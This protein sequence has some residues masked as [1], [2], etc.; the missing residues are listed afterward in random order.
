MLYVL[1]G[2]DD[3][4]IARS[5]EAIKKQIGDQAALETATTTL[6]GQKLTLDELRTVCETVPFLTEKRLVIVDGLLERFET[7]NRP[8]RQSRTHSAKSQPEGHKPF[9]DYMGNI[10]DSTVLVLTD[11]LISKAN[12]LLKDLPGK[13]TVQ[14]FPLLRE[15]QLREWV[16]K[17]V[18]AEGGNISPRAANLLARLV[19]SNLWI[20]SSEIN[21]LNL[22]AP[23]RPIEEDDIETMVGYSQQ[24]TVFIMI[25]AVLEFKAEL[26]EQSLHRLLQTGAASGYLLTMLA[27]QVQ[28]IVWASELK[29]QKRTNM[30]IQGKLGLNSEYVLRKVLEQAAR[31][32]LPRLKEVYHKL[33]ETDISIKTGKFD[34]DFALVILVAELSRRTKAPSTQS[35]GSLK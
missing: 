2:Q 23:G 3:Y 27:R 13:A 28:M 22:F 11:G 35:T 16:Q 7:R 33:L 20:L 24:T 25:D 1:T 30:E 6:A 5:L 4:S 15:P 34:A 14:D 17:Q 12:P 21:K 10:P 29:K 32:S 9:G 8:R 19:G 18:A 31:Y 26:A